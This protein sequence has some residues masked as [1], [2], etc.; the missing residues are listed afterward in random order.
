[1]DDPPLSRATHHFNTNVL[2]IY[3]VST[4]L[5]SR[6]GASE[7]RAARHLDTFNVLP[8]QRV[9]TPSISI[10]GSS[11]SNATRHLNTSNVLPVHHV[12]SGDK[13]MS[14]VPCL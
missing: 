10:D 4:P 6:D 1:M 12:G 13:R 7:S 3:P 5:I 14:Y 11:G 8:V 9:S 2:H